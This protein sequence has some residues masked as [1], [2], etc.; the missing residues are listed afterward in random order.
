MCFRSK[1]I[2]SCEE[3]GSSSWEY[4][5]S[6]PQTLESGSVGLNSFPPCCNRATWS[7][8]LL[9]LCFALLIC[10]VRITLTCFIKSEALVRHERV[11][12]HL[13]GSK[14]NQLFKAAV[15][16]ISLKSPTDSHFLLFTLRHPDDLL[17]WL[18]FNG[19]GVP[20]EPIKHRSSTF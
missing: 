9:L 19:H 6:R 20:R 17:H 7:R 10:Q 12:A 16:T 8:S 2:S 1:S 4:V 13:K 15:D 3:Y 14:R 18:V 11:P 5:A